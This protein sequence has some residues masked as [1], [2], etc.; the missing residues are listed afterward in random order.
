M[1][2]GPTDFVFNI[3]YYITRPVVIR[4]KTAAPSLLYID[5]ALFFYLFRFHH[6][7]VILLHLKIFAACIILIATW[8][9]Y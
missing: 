6:L 1:F 8:L 3:V 9:F 4:Q 2:D 5:I 7:C